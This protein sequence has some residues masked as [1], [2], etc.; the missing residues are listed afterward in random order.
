MYGPSNFPKPDQERSVEVV[1][2]NLVENTQ[3]LFS[4]VLGPNDRLKWAL[5]EVGGM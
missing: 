3:L 4:L 2:D 1:R 5:W